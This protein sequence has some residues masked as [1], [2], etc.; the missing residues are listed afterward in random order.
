ML[1]QSRLWFN[2]FQ[3]GKHAAFPRS[4]GETGYV[5]ILTHTVYT[6]CGGV[7]EQGK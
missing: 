2:E 5:F 1:K 3:N 4:S 6:V 7:G